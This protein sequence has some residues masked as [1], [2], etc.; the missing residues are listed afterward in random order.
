MHS[1]LVVGVDGSES[2]LRALDWALAEAARHD[3]P[4]RLVHASLWERYEGIRPSFAAER[5][6]DQV[7][8]EHIVASCAERA[9]ARDPG[10]RVSADIV[11]EDPVSAL[12]RAGQEAFAVVTGSRGRG[13]LPGLLLGS[14]GLGVAAHASCPVFVVRGDRDSEAGDAGGAAEPRPR[15]RVVVGVGEPSDGTSAVRFALGEAEARGCPLQAVRAWRHAVHH[16]PGEEAAAGGGAQAEEARAA[17][18]LSDVLRAAEADRGRTEVR[19]AVV[20]G[21]THR[22]LLAVSADADL[23]VVGALRRHGRV[24]LQLG[25]VAHVLLHH[26]ECPVA[27]VPRRA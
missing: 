23:V 10:V 5:P 16:R 20:E 2:S 18:L 1:P 7:M 27:I 6:T 8:A 25:R 21:A 11:P 13:A 15:G 17:Q 14:V 9:H 24:G 4:L 12:L 3:L 19:R 22:V 26:A